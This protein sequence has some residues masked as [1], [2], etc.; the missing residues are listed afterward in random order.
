MDD[1]GSRQVLLLDSRFESGTTPHPCPEFRNCENLQ[2]STL[3]DNVDF[4]GQQWKEDDALRVG[5]ANEM[6]T[7]EQWGQKAIGETHL[8]IDG[9]LIT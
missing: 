4:A 5:N 7:R 6:L 8:W 3:F 1:D 2:K 9:E